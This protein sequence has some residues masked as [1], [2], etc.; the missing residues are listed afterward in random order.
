MP[1]MFRIIA[2]MVSMLLF[3]ILSGCSDL[4]GIGRSNDPPRLWIS[5]SG[6]IL[7]PDGEV[8]LRATYLRDMNAGLSEP[9][10]ARWSSSNE[11]VVRVG[12]SGGVR[13]VGPGHA[14]VTVDVHG[15]SDTAIVEVRRPD[16]APE[17][18]WLSVSVG[19]ITTC[20]IDAERALWCWGGDYYGSLGSGTS[21]QWTRTLSP[22][23]VRIQGEFIEVAAGFR[24][25]C[26]RSIQGT[27]HCWGDN[28]GGGVGIGSEHPRQVLVPLPVA[29]GLS[30]SGLWTGANHTCANTPTASYCWGANNRGGLGI[31]TAGLQARRDSPTRVGVV[32]RFRSF[33]LGQYH[34]CGIDDADVAYCWGSG[35]MGSLG[36]GES[37]NRDA[38]SP[39]RVA[40]D[41]RFQELAAGND[42][43]CGL[44]VE[45]STLCWGWNLAFS[46][47]SRAGEVAWRPAEIEGDPGFRQL[48]AGGSSTCGITPSGEVY[49][50]GSNHTGVL[51][52]ADTGERCGAAGAQFICASRPIPLSGEI[53]FSQVSLGDNAGCG[54]TEQGSLYCWGSNRNG[55]LGNGQLIA[56]SRRPVA[57]ADPI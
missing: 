48:A 41:H 57:V 35:L 54:I 6:L 13:A 17:K 51:G 29:G 42:H 21:R 47:G 37:E 5:D 1:K 8:R 36:G 46:V 25:V 26:A 24:H 49:C 39:Q 52:E 43:V 9:A 55:Q 16:E 44:T 40:D 30:Y 53:R 20:A 33:A 14:V 27:A 31:G 15:L 12:P 18:R 23:R 4:V 45:G 7:E 22:V 28:A 3:T 50:W 11:A 10:D 2:S 19:G 34:S 38:V 32:S 56:E